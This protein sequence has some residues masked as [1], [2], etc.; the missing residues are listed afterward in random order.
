M[1]PS[2]ELKRKRNVNFN[3]REE[4]FLVELV[5]KYQQVIENKKTD[6]IMW[7]D[8]EACWVKLTAEFNSLGLLVPRTVAQLQ[9]KY[10]NLKKV[11][12][13]KS[14][15]IRLEGIMTGGGKNQAEP[16]D[17]VEQ[18][19]KDI[20]RLSVDGLPS[21]FDS[22]ADFGD[23][24]DMIDAETFEDNEVDFEDNCYV[25]VMPGDIEEPI[26]V[27]PDQILFCQ[28]KVDPEPWT[29]STS[30]TVGTPF[31]KQPIC[32]TN[33]LDKGAS[34]KLQWNVVTPQNLKQRISTPLRS[35]NKRS[36]SRSS[37]ATNL[38]QNRD[39]LVELQIKCLEQEYEMNEVKKK[40]CC[41]RRRKIVPRN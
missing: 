14:A 34:K 9:L 16:L 11:V 40:E 15:T 25:T 32:L 41:L 31:D 26:A 36:K 3:K 28:L 4:E 20:I 29:Q 18:K 27:I 33:Q 24:N 6:S 5:R 13:K 19:V 30:I 1:E 37:E 12:R 17:D 23:N 39:R 8:K 35:N 7:K 38:L 10:K 22:D 21:V 2:K